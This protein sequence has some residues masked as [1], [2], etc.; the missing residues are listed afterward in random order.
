[1]T[2][3]LVPYVR[4]LDDGVELRYGLRSYQT[5]LRL[6]PGDELRPLLLGDRPSWYA[7][8][9][10]PTPR[11][12]EGPHKA[13]RILAKVLAGLWRATENMARHDEQ[14]YYV[15]DD[16]FLLRPEPLPPLVRHVV[17]LSE[18]VRTAGVPATSEW[19]KQLRD[20]RDYLAELGATT[21]CYELHKPVPID[22]SGAIPVLID[23]SHD[24]RCL[25][26]R[27]VYGNLVDRCAAPMADDG[28]AVSGGRWPKGEVW[29]STTDASWQR[30]GRNMAQ[31]FPEPSRWERQ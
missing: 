12:D 30:V 27:S 25:G 13:G 6:P 15:S 4:G 10:L 8:E 20:T 22:V 5:N 17:D 24:P 28:R 16:Y 7:G 29:V 1:M 2:M 18:A 21:W 19:G 14:V 26:W 9:H 3:L 11:A 31:R 23:A